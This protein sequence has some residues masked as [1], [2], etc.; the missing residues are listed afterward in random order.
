MKA[1]DSSSFV[2]VAGRVTLLITVLLCR[3]LAS[4]QDTSLTLDDD[5]LRSAEQWARQ[6]LD[7]DALRVLQNV[8]R[9]KVQQLFAQIQRQF[10]GQ[11]VIDLAPL[12]DTARALLPILQNYE[13]TLPY[14]LWLKTR[15]DYLEVAD[16]FRLIIPPPKVPP[17]QPPIPIPNPAPQ[18]E[19]EIWITKL[20]QRPLPKMA[21]PYV[22][23]LKTIFAAQKIPPELVWLA[24]VESS[25]DPRARSPDGA[26]GLF[27]LMPGTAKRYG[28]RVGPFDQRLS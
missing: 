20:S 15:L 18:K 14:S 28:L 7:E 2:I 3:V 23:R 16:Q 12:K 11:Y 6:N 19:R 1:N 24:E 5:F 25:F 8:D 21:Q 27:Q 13:E 22:P 10:H 17:G 4:A 26:A 9:D